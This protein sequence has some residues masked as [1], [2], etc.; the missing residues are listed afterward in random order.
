MA[1]ELEQF[2]QLI[3]LLGALQLADAASAVPLVRLN[4]VNQMFDRNNDNRNDQ[5]HSCRPKHSGPI[6]SWPPR[7][8]GAF[9]CIWVHLGG[10]PDMETLK[11]GRGGADG[12][13]RAANQPPAAA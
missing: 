1:Q 3:K 8:L 10:V 6:H 5:R 7:D 2:N 4:L 12:N 11:V 13:R 9:G